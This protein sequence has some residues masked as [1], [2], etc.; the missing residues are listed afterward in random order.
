MGKRLSLWKRSYISKEER[1]TMIKSSLASLPLY[2]ISLVRMY[3]S[4]AK[5]L[6]NLQR[7][8]IWG[9]G[10]VNRKPHLVKWEVVCMTKEQGGLEMRKFPRLNKAL[11]G[12]W[13][14]R[15][16]SCRYLDHLTSRASVARHKPVKKKVRRWFAGR[17]SD[18]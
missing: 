11:L 1:I 6:E 14:W 8:F 7:N 18:D 4:V 5:R 3:V 2:Q 17:L 9:G 12:K 13:I 10:C 16:A 15:F